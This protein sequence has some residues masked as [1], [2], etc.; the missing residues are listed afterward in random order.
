[1]YLLE[2]KGFTYIIYLCHKYLER[3]SILNFIF[4]FLFIVLCPV[5]FVA[6]SVVLGNTSCNEGLT[7][8]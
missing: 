2:K 7:L 3:C 6:F 5:V 8:Q 4:I 1:V